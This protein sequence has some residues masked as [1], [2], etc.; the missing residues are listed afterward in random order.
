MLQ[1]MVAHVSPDLETN[2]VNVEEGKLIDCVEA[3]VPCSYHSSTGEL[4]V[5][6]KVATL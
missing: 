6:V 2:P 5:I 1:S 4:A 3:V